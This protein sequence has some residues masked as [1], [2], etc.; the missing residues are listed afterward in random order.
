MI[1]IHTV[2][3]NLLLSTKTDTILKIHMPL[4]YFSFTK[5]RIIRKSHNTTLLLPKLLTFISAFNQSSDP[6]VSNT[7]VIAQLNNQL[8][9]T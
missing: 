7:P 1:K 2:V 4:S 8:P 5:N 3:I 6:M 9:V